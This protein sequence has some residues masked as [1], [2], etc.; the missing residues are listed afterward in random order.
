M[1]CWGK[2]AHERID[3]SSAYRHFI[4]AAQLAPDNPL[5]LSEAGSAAQRIAKYN[6]AIKL[7]ETALASI[8]KTYGEDHPA[9]ATSRNNLGGAWSSLGEYKKAIG[10][11]ELALAA[12]KKRLGDNHPDT[13][14]VANNLKYTRAKATL[15]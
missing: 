9:V 10:Y 2:I 4:R 11:Y 12:F 3:Y 8:L 7:Y 13:Q 14:I 6:E 1:V 15:E 5:Y